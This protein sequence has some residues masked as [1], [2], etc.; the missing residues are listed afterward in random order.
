MGTPL[1]V[2]AT[3][4]AV[5]AQQVGLYGPTGPVQPAWFPAADKVQHALGFALPMF[6]VLMTTQICAAPA[7]RRMRPPWVAVAAGVFAA[8]AVISELVQARP[9]SGRTGDPADTVAD[10]VGIL[11]CLALFVLL[12]D[13]LAGDRPVRDPHAR[14]PHVG[15]QSG[16]ERL[17]RGRRG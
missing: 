16:P 17:G 4:A 1:L 9:G 12:R 8:N 15:A 6:L 13:R 3:L 11:L 14:D 5:V 10:L 2:L 7:G